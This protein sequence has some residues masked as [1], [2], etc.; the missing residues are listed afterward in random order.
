M[1]LAEFLEWLSAAPA[2]K[3]P[4]RPIRGS[5][6]SRIRTPQNQSACEIPQLDIRT[7]REKHNNKQGTKKMRSSVSELGRFIGAQRPQPRVDPN[8]RQNDYRLRAR[9]R[10]RRWNARFSA[11]G[12]L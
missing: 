4:V 1:D 9:G 3:I 10:Q 2:S 12:V 6:G 11:S 7:A 8:R 5:R